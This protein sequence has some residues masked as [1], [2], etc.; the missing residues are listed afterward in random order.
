MRAAFQ[1]FPAVEG[2]EKTGSWYLRRCPTGN[3]GFAVFTLWGT[4][5]SVSSNCGAPTR[6]GEVQR[7]AL[8]CTSP[9][10]YLSLNFEPNGLLDLDH[11]TAPTLSSSLPPPDLVAW[12]RGMSLLRR[13]DR[14]QAEQQRNSDCR[15]NRLSNNNNNTRCTRCLCA[16]PLQSSRSSSRTNSNLSNS[17]SSH[18]DI[19]SACQHRRRR[20]RRRR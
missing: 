13:L 9:E 8:C 16:R 7:S 5:K 20:R 18:K 17:H 19:P 3:G 12:M 15:R 11:S 1:L 6:L 4:L 14:H 10:P 2:E